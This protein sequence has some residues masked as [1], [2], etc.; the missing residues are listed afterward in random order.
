MS[1]RKSNR[2]GK[3]NG[4]PGFTLLELLVVIAVISI[5]AALLLPVLGKSKQKAWQTACSNNVRQLQ[6]GWIMYASDYNDYLPHNSCGVGA[7]QTLENPGWVAGNM[8]LNSDAG[9]DVDITESTNTDLL[10]G[11]QYA[12]FGSIGGYVKN[13]A[14]YRCPADTSIVPID[15][16]TFPRVRS[17]SMNNYMGAPE[18]PDFRFFMKMQ[19]IIAPGPSDAWVFM[20]EREDSINDGLFAVDA[21]ARYAIIDYPASYHNDGSSI[22]FA[23]GHTEYHKW[24]E[25]TT[26]PPL[27]V[28]QHLPGGSKPT[29]P[30]DR[31]MAW[32]VERTTSKN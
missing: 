4:P 12:P 32:L 3:E 30:N 8:W 25:P 15:G 23:D 2:R 13:P 31:D 1:R 28:D 11:N 9:Q 17:V 22:S 10:V 16:A 6:L 19:D 24:L 21:A 7:G 26:N 27:I 18:L 5:L 20:D 14:V 29:S